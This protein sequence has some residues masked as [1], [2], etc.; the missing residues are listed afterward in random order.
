M[1]RELRDSEAQ[2]QTRPFNRQRAIGQHR[3]Y[4]LTLGPGDGRTESHAAKRLP[5]K[6][7]RSRDVGSVGTEHS[8]RTD[9]LE[10]GFG[11]M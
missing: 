9:V 2:A 5:S 10:A 1:P 11:P 4:M 7:A 6:R 8:L 3:S